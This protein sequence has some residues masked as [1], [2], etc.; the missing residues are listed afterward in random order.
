MTDAGPPLRVR[1]V[2]DLVVMVEADPA[3]VAK[4]RA[5]LARCF[6]GH[7]EA[8]V[9][10]DARLLV[11]ELVTNSVQHAGVTATDHVVLRAELSDHLHVEVCD[12]GTGGRIARRL[13]DPSG[14]GGFGLELVERI[15]ARWGVRRGHRTCVWFELAV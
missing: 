2:R 9:L 11:S 15:A 14:A 1:G 5:A 13:P 6:D 4:A 8:E 3:G 10:V 7:V 12:P